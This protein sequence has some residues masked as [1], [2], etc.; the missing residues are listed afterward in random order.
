MPNRSF[1]D[2]FLEHCDLFRA[3]R[4]VA[5]PHTHGMVRCHDALEERARARV[6]WHNGG[7]GPPTFGHPGG[8]LQAQAAGGLRTVVTRYTG[9]IQQRTNRYAAGCLGFGFGLRDLR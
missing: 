2:P 9:A 6:A 4:C 1:V 7:A 8:R 3:K 5:E